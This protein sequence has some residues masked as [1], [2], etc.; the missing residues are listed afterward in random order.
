MISSAHSRVVYASAAAQSLFAGDLPA[1]AR[2][3]LLGAEPGA[4]RIVALSRSLLGPTR[5][6]VFAEVL[7]Y[8]TAGLSLATKLY[9]QL[10]L[11]QQARTY[12]TVRQGDWKLTVDDHDHAELFDLAND[13]M[14]TSPVQDP[15]RQAS[16]AGVMQAWWTTIPAYQAS[17]RGPDDKPLLK[18]R[19]RE[20]L[21]ALGYMTEDD[22]E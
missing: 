7:S 20:M 22:D 12:R 18:D 19:D 10:D 4:R 15:T 1:L 11:T 14:E 13:P 8:D 16:L 5:E 3:L 6:A 9:P 21:E 17:Q 2:R